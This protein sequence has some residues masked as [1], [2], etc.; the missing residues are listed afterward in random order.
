MN[1]PNHDISRNTH[2]EILQVIDDHG[3]QVLQFVLVLDRTLLQGVYLELLCPQLCLLPL[4][5][6][7]LNARLL[8]QVLNFVPVAEKVTGGNKQTTGKL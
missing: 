8:P 6:G 7:H 5:E 4:G 3:A 2:F 1:R